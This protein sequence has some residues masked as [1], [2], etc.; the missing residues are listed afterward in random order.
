MEVP[1]SGALSAGVGCWRKRTSAQPSGPASIRVKG[2]DEF[3]GGDALAPGKIALT[4][5]T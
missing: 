4:R 3:E 5:K 2:C 1:G